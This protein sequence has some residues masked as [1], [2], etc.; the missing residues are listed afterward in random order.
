VLI[1]LMGVNIRS[2]NPQL[3][4]NPSGGLITRRGDIKL[5]AQLL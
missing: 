1:N 3:S 2:S 4:P 5:D